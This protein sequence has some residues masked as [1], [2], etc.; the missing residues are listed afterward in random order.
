V[1]IAENALAYT[2]NHAPMPA[3]QNREGQGV[4]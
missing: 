3:A 4:L 1:R 2:F